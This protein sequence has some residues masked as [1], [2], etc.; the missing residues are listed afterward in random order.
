GANLVEIRR[1][2][3]P[4]GEFERVI[5]CA[6]TQEALDIA[7]RLVAPRGRLIIAG[8]HQD[9]PRTV[10]LQ[11]WNWRGLDVVNAHERDPLAV[12]AAIEEAARLAAAGILD[13]AA[14]ATHRFPLERLGEAFEA[15]RTRRDGFVKAWVA[16]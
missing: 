9:G 16:P 4:D 6:G 3:E 5:E 7:S 10:D 15:A 11:S 8:Y 14:L 2:D 1:G 13:L 12:V